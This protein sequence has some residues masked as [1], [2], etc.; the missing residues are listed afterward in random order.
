MI[1]GTAVKI[2]TNIEID[3]G[4]SPDSVSIE[5]YYPDGTEAQALVAMADDGGNQYS[6]IYQSA[7]GDPDGKYKVIV[8]AV[9]GSNTARSREY[10]TLLER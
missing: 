1:I 2:T 10:F 6:Y 7:V 3:G 4:G 5:I 8:T 9:E